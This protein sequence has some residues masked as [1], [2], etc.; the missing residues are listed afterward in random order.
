MDLPT[1]DG[2][3][4]KIRELQRREAVLTCA[5]DYGINPADITIDDIL[6][7]SGITALSAGAHMASVEAALRRLSKLMAGCDDRVRRASVRATAW[8]G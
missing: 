1:V 5:E 4:E 3:E 6:R 7:L 2:C 8:P